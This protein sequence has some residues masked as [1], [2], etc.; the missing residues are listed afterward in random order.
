MSVLPRFKNSTPKQSP[1]A[2]ARERPVNVETWKL[3]PPKL[4]KT[5]ADVIGKFNEPIRVRVE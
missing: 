4:L 2:R 3:L 5:P 1:W